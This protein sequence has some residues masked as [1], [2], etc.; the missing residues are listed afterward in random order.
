MSIFFNPFSPAPMATTTTESFNAIFRCALGNG[1][2]GEGCFILLKASGRCTRGC[3]EVWG[4]QLKKN[5]HICSTPY[6]PYHMIMRM[7]LLQNQRS[8]AKQKER[9]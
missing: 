8:R 9:N 4:Q 6:F 1:P 2:N 7:F 5:V 3:E